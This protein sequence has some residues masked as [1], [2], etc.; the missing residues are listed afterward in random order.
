MAR[1][2]P[3]KV[4]KRARLLERQA[5][6][7]VTPTLLT[8]WGRT[9]PSAARVVT[10]DATSKV[11]GVLEHAGRRGLEHAFDLGGGIGG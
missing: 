10:P 6:G 4:G 2:S 9:A 8:G 3:K 7:D 11:E 5:H 1:V